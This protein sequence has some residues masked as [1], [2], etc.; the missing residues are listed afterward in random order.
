MFYAYV[1]KSQKNF[2]NYIGSTENLKQKIHEHNIGTGGKFTSLN[3][4]YKLIYYEAYLN[5]KDAQRAEK[6]YKTG[7]V[8]EILKG[9]LN[10]DYDQSSEI[11]CLPA[12][13]QV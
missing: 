12:G 4:P 9:K 5:K 13:R 6:F 8:R 2:R 10:E 3:R 7:Y 11:A 1:L